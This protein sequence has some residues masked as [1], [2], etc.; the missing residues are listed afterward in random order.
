MYA[1]HVLEE[2]GLEPALVLLQLDHMVLLLIKLALEACA[3]KLC[4]DQIVLEML[5]FEPRLHDLIVFRSQQ[6]YLLF[7]QLANTELKFLALLAQLLD[8][9]LT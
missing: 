9:R 8:L 4:V 7:G 3:L 6:L 5:Q 1:R 2:L